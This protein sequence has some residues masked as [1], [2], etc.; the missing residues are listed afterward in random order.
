MPF[1][2]DTRHAY[3]SSGISRRLE[4]KHLQEMTCSR[5]VEKSQVLLQGSGD[6]VV[7][8]KGES[9]RHTRTPIGISAPPGNAAVDV[10]AL[11][12]VMPSAWV[13]G[14]ASICCFAYCGSCAYPLTRL[15]AYPL[16]RLP[17]YPITRLPDY[18]ITRWLSDITEVAVLNKLS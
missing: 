1:R 16:T 12:R 5:T 3:Y 15:P 17:D 11:F 6:L 4:T 8:L 18:P 13:Q 9:G 14:S 10:D 2:I 7:A